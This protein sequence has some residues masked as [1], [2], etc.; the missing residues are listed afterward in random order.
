MNYKIISSCS[1]GNAVII[2]D[3]ILI[4]CG[5]TFK[6]LQKYYKNLKIVINTYSH[7]PL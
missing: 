7:R 4:D 6:R 5:V 1:S 3:I 2:K